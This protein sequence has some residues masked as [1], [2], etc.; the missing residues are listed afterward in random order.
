[1]AQQRSQCKITLPSI[2][3]LFPEHLM[4]I[5][6]AGTFRYP[7]STSPADP[8]VCGPPSTN[9]HS[10]VHSPRTLPSSGFASMPNVRDHVPSIND[11]ACSQAFP[12]YATP[13]AF[14]SAHAHGGSQQCLGSCCVPDARGDPNASGSTR[15]GH[16][17]TSSQNVASSDDPA[18]PPRVPTAGALGY[19]PASSAD[20]VLASITK[21]RPTFRVQL[22]AQPATMPPS[23]AISARSNPDGHSSAAEPAYGYLSNYAANTYLSVPNVPSNIRTPQRPAQQHLLPEHGASSEERRHRCPHCH[24]RFNRPSSLNIHVNTHTGAKP[25]VCRY[26]GCNRTFNVNSN[27]R[28]HYRN[29]LTTRRRDTVAKLVRPPS[30]SPSISAS[31]SPEDPYTQHLP[32]TASSSSHTSP[33]S[34]Y[35]SDPEE[36]RRAADARTNEQSHAYDYKVDEGSVSAYVQ[37]PE[38]CVRTD[39]YRVRSRSSPTPRYHNE[40]ARRLAQSQSQP[41]PNLRD[42]STSTSSSSCTI[43]GCTCT[44]TISTALRPAFPESLPSRSPYAR[45]RVEYERERERWRSS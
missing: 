42:R 4:T 1:M 13:S 45:E 43:P 6:P 37:R 8:G 20:S 5:P 38:S 27:M 28:R 12:T 44:V 7:S 3:E 18:V 9:N 31:A 39:R 36:E 35:Y 32:S 15:P 41:A 25:F 16:A 11:R 17:A 40:Q 26:P 22:N 29:H 10:A 19:P 34:S 14:V 2:N 23:L 30:A 24:K 21:A 33:P